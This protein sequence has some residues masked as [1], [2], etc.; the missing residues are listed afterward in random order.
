MRP[1]AR[2]RTARARPRPSGRRTTSELVV[3]PEKS[4]RS[5]TAMRADHRSEHRDEV[6][7]SLRAQLAHA[8]SQV[9]GVP[10]SVGMGHADVEG[11]LVARRL[12]ED[13]HEL[14]ERFRSPASALEGSDLSV[15]ERQDRLDAQQLAGETCRLAYAPASDE[16]V[17]RVDG[18]EEAAL[19]AE[20]L[21]KLLDRLVR[22][23]L[24]EPPLDRIRE[25]NG[26]PRDDTRIDHDHSLV[27]P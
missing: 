16:I 23:S 26:S 20:A 8:A 19:A 11:R 14:G 7:R 2:A 17:E 27:V 10:R 24:L 1:S 25:Q 6:Q 18:E 22:R 21:H 4:K 3:I 15:L 5:R 9:L 13:A 12:G